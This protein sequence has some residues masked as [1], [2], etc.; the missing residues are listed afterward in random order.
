[1][2]LYPVLSRRIARPSP[3][4]TPHFHPASSDSE[5]AASAVVGDDVGV[6]HA[7][8]DCDDYG[9]A[10]RQLLDWRSTTSVSK[11]RRRR[12]RYSRG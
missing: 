1:M 3:G 2:P 12:F 7:T 6:D 8:A 5:D 10:R 4:P 9:F 11:V